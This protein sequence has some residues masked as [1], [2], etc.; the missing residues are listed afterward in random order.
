MGG[1]REGEMLADELSQ[2]VRYCQQ[3]GWC[4]MMR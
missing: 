1:V 3:I 4:K 2:L